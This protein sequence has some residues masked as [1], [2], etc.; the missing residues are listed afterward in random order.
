MNSYKREMK[1][2][3]IKIGAILSNIWCILSALLLIASSFVIVFNYTI[4][5]VVREPFN[6]QDVI[7]NFFK[8]PLISPQSIIFLIL[9]VTLGRYLSYKSLKIL[10]KSKGV[11]NE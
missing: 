10:D 2:E 7:K 9:G 3:L 6:S 1:K 5:I 8:L 4:L 11:H